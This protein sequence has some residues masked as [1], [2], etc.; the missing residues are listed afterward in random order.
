MA[1]LPSMLVLANMLLSISVLV[2][3]T[4]IITRSQPLPDDGT[5]TL[6]S[7]DGI[8][9][10]GFFS[11]GSS[12][13]RYV[14]I[15]FKR[16]RRRTIVWVANR[17]KPIRDNSGM[18]SLNTQG[19]LVL[20]SQNEN[21]I[22]LANS[23]RKALS[24]IVQLL[25]SGNLVIRNEKDQSAQNYLW[26][27]F[28]YPS[29]TL[30]PGMKLGWDVKTGLNRRFTA[31]KSWDD[32]SLGDFT[33]ELVVHNY[34]EIVYWW[35][36]KEYFRIGPW[37]GLG[38]SGAPRTKK[39]WIDDLKFVSN[40]DEVYF[41]YAP[42]NDSLILRRVLNQTTYSVETY[43]WIENEK[44]WS[45]F[46]YLPMDS[47]DRYNR[48]GPYGNCIID[49]TPVCQCLKGFKP[50]SP[51]NWE[52]MDWTQGCIRSES[53]SCKVKKRDNFLKFSG[54]K[55]P[56]TTHSWVNA[57]M[58]LEE[59]KA[60][61]WENCSCTAYANSDISGGGS[62]CAIWFGDLIDM[63]RISDP[64]QVI[65]IR[66]AAPETAEQEDV[67]RN[68]I[69]VIVM[70]STIL[71]A[72][73]FSFASFYIYNSRTK[74]K[75]NHVDGPEG[76]IELPFFDFAVIVSVTNNFSIDNKLGQ[77]GF[78]P[79]YKGILPNGQEIAVK[80][81]SQSSNQGIK[82]FQNE[83][84]LC[85]KLQHRNLVKVL[86]CYIQGGEKMLIYEYMPNKSL[87]S[88]IFG[89][90][91]QSKLLDWSKRFH[92]ICGIARGPMYL[93][94]DSR[95]KII[96]WDIKASNILLD[97]E[98]N[99]KISDFGLA[100]IFGGDQVEENTNRVIGTYGYMAPEYAID[101]LFSTKSDV[102]SFGILLLEIVSGMKN[103]GLSHPNQSLNL[104]GHAWWLWKDG[105]P[106]KLIDANLREFC[107][108]SEVLRCIH[109]GLLCVQHHP[110]DR[111]DMAS[112]VVML[113]SEVTLPQPKEPEFLL[114]KTSIMG[115]SSTIVT[116]S[117]NETS[118]TELELQVRCLTCLNYDF[119]R[120]K[121]ATKSPIIVLL[122][123]T[124]LDHA[125]SSNIILFL[126]MAIL[127]YC[128]LLLFFSKLLFF[129]P[130]LLATATTDTITQSQPLVDDGKSTLVSKDGRFELGFFSPGSSTN[131]Y[132]G[133]WYKNVPVRYILWVANREKP[134]K[135]RLGM[136]SIN[137]E[138][139]LVVLSQNK[140]LLW[141]A[142]S[143]TT[144]KALMSPIVQLLDSGNLV[145]RDDKD[146]NPQNYL[147]QSFD[148]Y[149]NVF[150]PGMKLGWDLRTGLN[151][152]L[153]AWKNW[154][155]PSP[156][157]FTCELMLHSYPEIYTW[158]GRTKYY[159]SGPWNGDHFVD[160]PSSNKMLL[161]NATLVSN[162]DEVY[163]M[164]V[165][166]NESMVSI[167]VLNQTRNSLQNLMWVEE[168]QTW[169]SFGDVPRD[170]CGRYNLCGAFGIC[171]IVDST[172]CQCLKGFE[173]KSPKNWDM[174]DWT[175]GCVRSKPWSCKVK[176][177]DNFVKYS[178]LKL[179]DTTYT[180]VNA[181]MTLDECKAK[182]WEN[183]SCTAYSFSDIRGGGSGCV[184]WF[185]DL[186]DLNQM[187]NDAGQDLYIRLASTDIAKHEGSN[188]YKIKVAA[189][190]A[191]VFA[192]WMLLTSLYIYKSRRKSKENTDEVPEGDMDLPL[193]DFAI[194]ASATQNF[195]DENKL[196]QGG[197]GPVY[198]GT[199]GGGQEIAVKRLSQNSH[200]G[201]REFKNEVMLCAKLQHRNLAKVLGC[202]IGGE[203]KM[204]IYEYMSN[205]SLD[206]FIFGSKLLCWFKRFNIICGIARGL[207]YLHQDSRLRIIHRD[208]KASN[209]LLD[210]DLNPK[211]SDFGL[212]KTFGKD[213]NVENTRRV[214]GTYGYMAPEYAIYGS[215]SMKSDVFSFGILLLEIVSGK[216]NGAFSL[217]NKNVNLIGLAWRLW[218]EGIPL[219]LIDPHMEEPYNE[220]EV[221]RCIH[222]GLLCVQNHPDDRPNMA[223]VVV[224]LSSEGDLPQPKEPGFLLETFPYKKHGNHDSASINEISI[225]QLVPR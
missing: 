1:I 187:S 160:T 194:I 69:M 178:N 169:K 40:K 168:D 25:D 149:S 99:P 26:Q 191:T 185:G 5:T 81:L 66:L 93:H 43:I 55:L 17:E 82:E 65:Y 200:Q 119:S 150:L 157:D 159:R 67:D 97:N 86:G 41:T 74:F 133:L 60:K 84:L 129:S 56:D 71:M 196:G 220:S 136:M 158:Q 53:W 18:L 30:L 98:L 109:I 46:V 52:V 192:L 121:R 24:P 152:R 104:I 182:C 108:A 88:L 29:D 45:T 20:L 61:C 156:G 146:Q 131:R 31:W 110:G 72:V 174:Y 162:K 111:P 172:L 144:T 113:S 83:V 218:K 137:K 132:V 34:P 184:M 163:Y 167:R 4:D 58:T 145:L 143:T 210:N 3:A 73:V 27:S 125:C 223:S 105:I 33:A 170:N 22:W 57:S 63:K 11:P 201:M 114:N 78:G 183:C 139:H 42:R 91:T 202:C 130:S 153:V 90:I 100:R 103:R 89:S 203:E 102:F 112:V 215:F 190:T 176:G 47:C 134:A 64:D 205:K 2:S 206:S 101:G 118:L 141:V 166:L 177:K 193:Y 212:A 222:I 116:S 38:F 96:H 175:G 126:I 13:N 115:E 120:I 138:G 106:L 225:T 62:G 87:D 59:C 221:L 217:A 165:P 123:P 35:G 79:V 122:L 95:L 154:D 148:H 179:P 216:K 68:K 28:D 70:T 171:A 151:R 49:E 181:S 80:R 51:R 44:S 48:C 213:E 140:T 219:E 124:L 21:I 7:K 189:I 85:A 16:I 128:L 186:L 224:M 135:D 10:L 197:F 9:E 195:S 208:L 12:T 142:N 39:N 75:G 37:N 92:I 211:I 188:S 32:P 94:Q 214:I 117:I 6:T 76:D 8:F 54:L 50:K 161:Y 23:T 36:Q 207:T 147:W 199:L 209:I 180:W 77:G 164:Y 204:L 15:W 127:H 19:N 198:K 155:D 107:I 14:G 173:P